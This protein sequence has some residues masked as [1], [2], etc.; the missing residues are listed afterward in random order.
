MS[1][2]QSTIIR[3]EDRPLIARM[4]FKDSGEPFDLVGWTKITVQFRKADRS[5]LD[6]DSVLVGGSFATVLFD[7][8]NYTATNIGANGN[9]ISLTADGIKSIATLVNDWN[10]ANPSNGLVH[11]ALDDTVVPVAG[12]ILLGGGVDQTRSVEVI[13]EV[14]SKISIDLTDIDT[15]ALKV[16]PNQSFK[17]IVDKGSDRRIVLFD[18]ALNVINADI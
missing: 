2:I 1:N 4:I 16:G 14:L 5:I 3:G 15:N 12:N 11:D 13:S 8:V 10:T 7:G 6:K 17:V 18:S 9:L